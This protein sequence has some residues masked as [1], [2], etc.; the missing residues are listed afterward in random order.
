MLSLASPHL[1]RTH[2]HSSFSY[3]KGWL[4]AARVHGDI[5]SE[6]NVDQAFTLSH[7]LT[8]HNSPT[9]S[10]DCSAQDLPPEVPLARS[11]D[12]A[13]SPEVAKDGIADVFVIGGGEIYKEA[14]SHPMCRR[15]YLTRVYGPF[16]CDAFF[17]EGLCVLALD[18]W[19]ATG[20]SIPR[21]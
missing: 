1:P 13:L 10:L 6:S 3:A 8:P 14:L 20:S 4:Q 15:V 2:A 11:L 17:P 5:A 7:P 12:E 16:D 18:L 9:L 21:S 19:S